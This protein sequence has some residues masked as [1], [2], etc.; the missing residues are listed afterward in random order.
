SS[1]VKNIRQINLKGVQRVTITFDPFRDDV[2]NTRDFLF[3]LS[4]PT[5]VRSNPNCTVKSEIVCDR[6]PSSIVFSLIPSVQETSKLKDIRINSDNLNVL[7]ILQVCNKYVSTLAPK[8]EPVNVIKTKSE[9]KAGA[10]RR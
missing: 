7:E 2:K 5:I 1:I 4:T 3:F 6:S 8:E 10:K 9:K